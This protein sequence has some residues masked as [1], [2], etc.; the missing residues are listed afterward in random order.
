MP[1]ASASA[2]RLPASETAVDLQPDPELEALPAPPRQE[3]V[4]TAGLMLMA[5]V[6][7][8]LLAVSLRSEVGYVF[9]NN[10][11][12][13]IGDLAQAT[14][15]ESMS[16]RYIRATG[17]LSS[18]QAIRYER[19]MEGDSFRLAPIANNPKV[20]V[21]IRVPEGMEGPRFTPPTTFAGRLVPMA[22]AGLRHGGL[23]AKLNGL[24]TDRLP[25]DAWLLVDGSS[26]RA[27]RWSLALLAILS[28][29]ILWNVVGMIRLFR[30]IP[31]TA[32]A[33]GTSR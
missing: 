17:L 9:S 30:R 6:A 21:E 29:F 16:N 12:M 20:W 11:P 5:A 13:D 1:Q 7:S 33:S 10:I 4:F 8:T 25:P 28:Y 3:R 27:S 24:T 14:L 32:P 19:P 2:P 15:S 31:W 26:P 18:T 22:N 23:Q